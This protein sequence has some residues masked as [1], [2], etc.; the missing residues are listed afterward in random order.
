[1]FLLNPGSETVG[2]VLVVLGIGVLVGVQQLRYH[3]FFE[4]KQE[5]SRTL[6][7]RHVIANNVSIRR[8]AETLSSCETVADFCLILQKCLQPI[9]FDGFGI[10]LV[11]DLPD[12]VECFPLRQTDHALLYHLWDNTLILSDTNWRLSFTL[13]DKQGRRLGSFTLFRKSSVSPLWI[14]LSVFNTTGF[15]TALAG[16]IE[17]IQAEWLAQ[18]QDHDLT[19]SY[20]SS[21][22]SD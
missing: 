13:T 1:L 20:E 7:L 5:A 4:L 3:E 12:G 22:A 18:S 2:M 15:S 17:K 11:A 16:K 19:P 6:N 9:G 14:D 21:A 8:S 10:N